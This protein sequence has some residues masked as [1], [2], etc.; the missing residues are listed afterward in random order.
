MPSAATARLWPILPRDSVSA[1]AVSG[2]YALNSCAKPTLEFEEP[3]STLDARKCASLQSIRDCSP[4]GSRTAPKEDRA[5]VIC[6]I[7]VDAPAINSAK[8]L[9]QAGLGVR[10]AIEERRASLCAE[11]Q[12]W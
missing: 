8:A 7:L 5:R 9:Q 1:T 10:T 11:V 4:L 6:R 12:R 2:I 3:N